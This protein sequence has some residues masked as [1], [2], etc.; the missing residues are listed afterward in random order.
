[1]IKNKVLVNFHGQ[2]EDLT[3]DTGKMGNKMER[4][5]IETRKDSKR[6]EPG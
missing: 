3:K 5:H 1:M 4:A 6:T 2:M